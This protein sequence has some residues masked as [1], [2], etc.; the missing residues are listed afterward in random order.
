MSFI[1]IK[2]HIPQKIIYGPNS[3]HI[4]GSDNLG[5]ETQKILV[6]TDHGLLAT[7]NV[8]KV[9]R[10]LKKVD[11]YGELGGEPTSDAVE[12]ALRFARQNDYDLVIG[13]GGGSALDTAKVVA[14]LK[15][16]SATVTEVFG[17]DLVGPRT[18]GLGLI[19]TTAGTGSE[20]TPNSI[21]LDSRDGVKKAVIS[22]ELIPDWV[23][24]DPELTLSLPPAI[25]ASTGID[26][27]CHCIESALS[28]NANAISQAYSYQ[29]MN[30][31]SRNIKQVVVNGSDLEARGGMLWGSFFGGLALTIAGTT[32]VHALSYPLGKRGVP[33]GVANAMLLPWILEYNRP[34]CEAQLLGLTPYLHS[35]KPLRTA[36]DIVNLAFDYVRTLPVPQI[37]E[38]VGIS[39]EIVSELAAEAMDQ[40]RLLNNNPRPMNQAEA[41]AVYRQFLS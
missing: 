24:L 7:G 17:R 8:E 32:A 29:G 18:V 2:N 14:V 35:E 1:I 3:V 31:L 15:N 16:Q 25:T 6:I 12:A 5:L 36:A 4:I 27:F 38:E 37:L 10:L 33:H 11:V 40:T 28:V 41:E 21:I 20:A 23:V 22:H 30:L 13:I 19:P 34:V 9:T 39:P 26:A